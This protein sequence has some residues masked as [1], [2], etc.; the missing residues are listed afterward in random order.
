MEKTEN[1]EQVT[2]DNS[3]EITNS[4]EKIDSYATPIAIVVAAIILSGAWIYGKRVAASPARVVQN[5]NI[6]GEQDPGVPAIE[7]QITPSNGVVLPA[8]WGSLGKQLIASGAIDSEKFQTIYKNR[9][10]LTNEYKDLLLGDK[11][12]K[13]KITKEN[14]GYYLNLFWALG[15]SNKSVILEKGPMVD[16]RF[17]GAQNFASTGG[18]TVAKGNPMDHYSKHV[19]FSLTQAQEALVEKVA[20]GVYRPCCGNSTIFPDCNHGMAMLGL[21]ELLA[22]QGATEQQMWNAALTVNSYWFPDTYATIATYMKNKGVEWKDVSPKEVLGA[23]YSSGQGFAKISAQVVQ[24]HQ[25]QSSG[26]CGVD[27]GQPAVAQPKPQ[28]GCGV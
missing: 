22:S 6:T 27:A 11:N 7:D 14:A 13:I 26:G 9:N 2:I 24:P 4:Q 5:Q 19:Y 20:Q 17:G 18:W 10:Q 16:P 1:D 8:T 15:L 25:H 3:Q 12:G 28:P 23:D 21:L